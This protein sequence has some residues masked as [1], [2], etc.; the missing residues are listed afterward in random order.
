[1]KNK[2][3]RNSW[4]LK[5]LS[6]TVILALTIPALSNAQTGKTNFSG[7]WTVNNDKSKLPEGPG[8]SMRMGGGEMVVTQS[9]NNLTV[10]RTRTGRNGQEMTTTDKYSL[11]GKETVN[12]TQ[13]GE[14]KSVAK[15]SDDGKSITITTNMTFNM[16]G[17][18]REI[19]S[20]EVWTLVNSSTLSIKST[21]NGRNGD[22]TMTLVYDKK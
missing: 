20:T 10:E 8:G 19:K 14:S 21:R 9:G 18:S 7:K 4:F 6:L 5:A 11:D 17:Q 13:R 2:N 15:W 12:T 22:I 16:N 1:M 3:V